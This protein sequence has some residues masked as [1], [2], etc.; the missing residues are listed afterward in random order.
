[1][2]IY[3][4]KHATAPLLLHLLPLTTDPPE[5]TPM[6]IFIYTTLLY[7]DVNHCQ[8]ATAL[9]INW[10]PIHQFTDISVNFHWIDFLFLATVFLLVYPKSD[11]SHHISPNPPPLT[12]NILV[13]PANSL[14]LIAAITLEV[15]SLHFVH[16]FIGIYFHQV[17]NP[18]PSHHTQSLHPPKHHISST[19]SYIIPHL[20]PWQVYSQLWSNVSIL[21]ILQSSISTHLNFYHPIKCHTADL[22]P[23]ESPQ[24]LPFPRHPNKYHFHPRKYLV[25]H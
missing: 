2:Y 8:L 13:F 14:Q 21:T 5:T 11:H 24:S 12:L 7:I 4:H 1:M 16:L 22:P 6:N 19:R 23:D 17:D 9:T 18:I 20:R 25:H 15:C 3:S 10:V